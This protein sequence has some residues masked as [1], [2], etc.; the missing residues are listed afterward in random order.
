MTTYTFTATASTISGSWDTPADWSGSP[1]QTAFYSPAGLRS[2]FVLISNTAGTL[3]NLDQG[4]STSPT[5]VDSLTLDDPNL[6]SIFGNG[7]ATFVQGLTLTA[8]TIEAGSSTANPVITVGNGGNPGTLQ[9]GGT[10]IATGAPS[11]SAPS[12]TIDGGGNAVASLAGNGTINDLAGAWLDVDN[13]VSL[14]VGS[15]LTFDVGTGALLQFDGDV[16]AGTVNFQDA[17]G[18]LI[19]TGGTLVTPDGNVFVNGGTYGATLSNLE[20]GNSTAGASYINIEAVGSVASATLVGGNDIQVTDQSGDTYNFKLSGN[21]TGDTATVVADTNPLLGGFDVLLVCYGAGTAILTSEGEAPVESIR[22]GDIVMTLEGGAHVPQTVK[23]VGERTLDLTRHPKREQVAPVRVLKGALGENLPH[24]DLVLS[25]DHCLLID[26]GL[27]PAKLLVN[28]MT[29]VRD[30]DAKTV[31][32]HHVELDQHA[33]LIAE[34]VAAESYLDTGN[35]AFFSNAGLATLL[36]PDLAINENLRC[37]EEDACAPL[38]VK[39]DAVKPVWDRIAARA[40]SLGFTPVSSTVTSDAAVRLLVDGKQ[41]RPITTRDGVASFVV[42]AGAR[43]VRLLSRATTPGMI[44]PW[45]DDFRS[46][47]VAIHSVTLRDRSGVAV[48]A[49]D[50]PA[51]TSGWHAAEQAEDGTIW[52]WTNGDASLPIQANGACTVE[53]AFHASASYIEEARLAA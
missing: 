17:A 46:L 48:M 36:H 1:A 16:N 32:Y 28:G 18:A 6:V 41:I 25:P 45:H 42:P 26:G 20:A 31:T 27:I 21:F 10:L 34:G 5:F 11:S 9:V 50:H 33:V 15:S 51:L 14:A 19:V 7:N 53:V 2:D 23:W 52:R 13:N 29:I 22:A 47:G 40:E 44:T 3:T 24:R 37:W 35:R 43:S 49:A 4:S 8:G 38:T 39:P 30:M 12:L